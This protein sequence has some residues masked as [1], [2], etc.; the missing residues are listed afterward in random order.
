MIGSHGDVA[1]KAGHSV[2]GVGRRFHV[3]GTRDHNVMTARYEMKVRAILG[4]ESHDDKE[5]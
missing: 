1:R 2:C 3:L 4:P 5:V